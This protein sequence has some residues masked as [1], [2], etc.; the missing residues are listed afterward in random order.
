MSVEV[1]LQRIDGVL[2]V[3]APIAEVAAHGDRDRD[4]VV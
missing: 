4:K 3:R 2:E 1:Q